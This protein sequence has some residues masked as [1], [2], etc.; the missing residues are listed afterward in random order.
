MKISALLLAILFLSCSDVRF[1]SKKIV[2]KY[3]LKNASILKIDSILSYD[4]FGLPKNYS[5]TDCFKITK[6]A[7]KVNFHSDKFRK[8]KN[9][10]FLPS[11]FS[12]NGWYLITGLRTYDKTMVQILYY[13]SNGKIKFYY[14][15][16]W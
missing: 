12:N 15:D 4:N 3:S 2:S 14:S 16:P 6:R 11:N 8:S 1:S 10:I 9:K 13:K 7:Y 5:F